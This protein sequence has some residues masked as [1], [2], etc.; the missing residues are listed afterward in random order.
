MS[1]RGVVTQGFIVAPREVV[2]LG[3]S[4]GAP[5]LNTGLI[6]ASRKLGQ[7]GRVQRGGPGLG[8][9]VARAIAWITLPPNRSIV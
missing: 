4:S 6:T 7:P 9:R 8:G 3:F 1:I 5:P 2:T